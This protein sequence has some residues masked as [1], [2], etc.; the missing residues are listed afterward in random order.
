V[1]RGASERRPCPPTAG[2]PG[3]LAA[4]LG[5]LTLTS[6][7]QTRSPT[8]ARWCSPTTSSRSSRCAHRP[9]S[10]PEAQAPLCAA[11]RAAAAGQPPHP[12]ASRLTRLTRLLRRAAPQDLDPLATLSKL[13][14]LSL[15]ENPV[16]K[17]ANYR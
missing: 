17:K 13:T 10:A 9:R 14:R 3:W 4:V 6:T 8:S 16:T 12:P 1:G 11:A 2:H 7:P 5:G 15:L